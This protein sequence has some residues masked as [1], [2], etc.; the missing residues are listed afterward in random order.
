MKKA[1]L[2]LVLSFIFIQCSTNNDHEEEEQQEI[3]EYLAISITIKGDLL[4]ENREKIL[5][6]SSEEGI[7]KG[8]IALQNNQENLLTIQREPNTE[9]HLIIH[10]KLTYNGRKRHNFNIFKNIKSSDYTLQ[11]NTGGTSGDLPNVDLHIFNTGN[12]DRLG[13]TGGGMSSWSSANGGTFTSNGTSLTDPGDYYASF[14]R[15]EDSFARYFWTENME[16]DKSFT[17]DFEEL[18][19]AQLVE[20]HLPEHVSATVFVNGYR[21]EHPS[22]AHRLSSGNTQGVQ[23]YETYFPEEA[24]FDY[25]RFSAG[26]FDGNKSYSVNSVSE[27]IPSS[28]EVPSFDLTINNFSVDDTNYTTTGNYDISN[29]NFIISDDNIYIQAIV[30]VYSEHNSE[31]SFSIGTLMDSFFED[32]P[33]LDAAQLVPNTITLSSYNFRE[34]Y[35]EAVKGLIE[36][37][38][39]RSPG[40]LSETISLKNN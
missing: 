15:Q 30:K 10:D 34:N 3:L 24:V 4:N 16:E 31:V 19:I 40:N 29:A 6:I 12:I 8:K 5:Y 18:P 35:E 32:L 25:I 17:L 11:A 26:F 37:D 20:T 23:T 13:M 14:K 33:S 39:S 38:S 21:T 22:A 1:P 28:I 36:D 7:I 2:L 27:V 9:Y